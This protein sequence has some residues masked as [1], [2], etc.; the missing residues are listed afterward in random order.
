[1]NRAGRHWL[2]M[3]VR[4]VFVVDVSMFVR[5]FSV[6][7]LVFVA[8]GQVQP[9]TGSHQPGCCKKVPGHRIA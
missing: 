2:S 3:L 7:V 6:H 8:L 1:M 4:V 5:N 9:D